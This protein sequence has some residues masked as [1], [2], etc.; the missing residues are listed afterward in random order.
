MS[1]HHE[2]RPRHYIAEIIELKTREER[3]L[4]LDKVPD[5]YKDW[6]KQE[7]ILYFEFKKFD[8][9]GNP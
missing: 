8:R 5:K 7:V 9:R 4:A 3:R 6:V 1:F 2:K